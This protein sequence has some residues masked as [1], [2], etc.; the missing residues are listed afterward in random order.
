M[1]TYRT[2]ICAALWPDPV[3]L[4]EWAKLGL[5]VPVPNGSRPGC[6]NLGGPVGSPTAWPISSTPS[7]SGNDA[8]EALTCRGLVIAWPELTKPVMAAP[9]APAEKQKELF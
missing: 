6:G 8:N 9:A 5:Q 3:D 4:C 1:A 7:A 2:V